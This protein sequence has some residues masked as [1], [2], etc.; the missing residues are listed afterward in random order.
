V[1]QLLSH[2]A[3][4]SSVV[5]LLAGFAAAPLLMPL[6]LS[7]LGAS[8]GFFATVYVVGNF[9]LEPLT[10]TRRIVVVVAAASA[11]GAVADLAFKPTR[12]AGLVLGFFCAAGVIW[13]F[14]NV[15]S[16]QSIEGREQKKTGPTGPVLPIRRACYKA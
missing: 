15:L 5:P 2:P 8:V 4:Q 16:Q 12:F 1:Q 7:G 14:W 10:A 3:F 6:R 13:A 9:A 11:I